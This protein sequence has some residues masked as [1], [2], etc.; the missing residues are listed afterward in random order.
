MKYLLLLTIPFGLFVTFGSLGEFLF[1]STFQVDMDYCAKCSLNELYNQIPCRNYS[2][3][4]Q[5]DILWVLLLISLSSGVV[6]FLVYKF[7]KKMKWENDFIYLFIKTRLK[8]G[9]QKMRSAKE[10]MRKELENE[11]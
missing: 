2:T 10:K 6:T 3:R 11:K 8:R 7:Y 1:R 9:S 4:C 5:I